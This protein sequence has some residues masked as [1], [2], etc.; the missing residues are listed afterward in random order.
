[1]SE[2]YAIELKGIT[3]TFGSVVEGRLQSYCFLLIQEGTDMAKQGF[4]EI[5]VSLLM[6][7][8][9][10]HYLMNHHLCQ[11][12]LP[13]QKYLSCQFLDQEE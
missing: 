12:L 3:K 5:L 10:R 7:M 11:S 6:L 9:Y 1:M 8:P 2:A 13:H 4:Q